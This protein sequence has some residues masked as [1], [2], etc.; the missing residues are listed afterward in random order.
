MDTLEGDVPLATMI[1][2]G[3]PPFEHVS[4]LETLRKAYKPAGEWQDCEIV[5]RGETLSVKLNGELVTLAIGIKNLEGHIGIQG[6]Y[7]LLEFRKIDVIP[8]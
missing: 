7:G 8:L 5:C 3:A 1:P 2:Y 4:N 6:E